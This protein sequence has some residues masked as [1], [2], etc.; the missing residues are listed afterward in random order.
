MMKSPLILKWPVSGTFRLIRILLSKN[1]IRIPEKLLRPFMEDSTPKNKIIINDREQLKKFFKNGMLPTE[2]HF[3]ILID[4]MFNK[5]DDGI[6]KNDIDGLMV[7]P[8]GDQQK[9]LSF[10]DYIRSEEHTS[11]L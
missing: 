9:L 10:Y 1:Q 2:N 5:V 3:A 8:A 4:S 7:F 11:E 6:S